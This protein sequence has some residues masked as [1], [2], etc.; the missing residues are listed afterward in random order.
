M[1][2]T[3]GGEKDLKL[4]PAP[5]PVLSTGNYSQEEADREERGRQEADTL[6]L[7]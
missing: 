2:K 3:V 6:Q 5:F 7:C 1:L 4:Y